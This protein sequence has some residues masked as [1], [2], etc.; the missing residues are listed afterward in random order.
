MN[1]NDL[2]RRF[3]QIGLAVRLDAPAAEQLKRATSRENLFDALARVEQSNDAGARAYL[4]KALRIAGYPAFPSSGHPVADRGRWYPVVPRQ[5]QLQLV[6]SRS[7]TPAVPI[8]RDAGQPEPKLPQCGTEIPEAAPRPRRQQHHVYGARAA[9]TFESD[10]TPAG[11]PTVAIDA[12]R[13]ISARRYDWQRKVRIQLTARELPVVAAV[14]LRLRPECRFTN[15]GPANDK[16]L[17]IAWQGERESFFVQLWQ[18]TGHLCAVPMAQADGFY[19]ARLLDGAIQQADPAG[20]VAATL[21]CLRAVF[22][23]R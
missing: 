21:T 20:G 10:R 19:V 1:L 12:A 14:L 6:R 22:A 18:G 23:P 11:T 5:R 9:L 8:E 4:E 13:C 2:N 16:G 7:D 15:H 3:A 17:A